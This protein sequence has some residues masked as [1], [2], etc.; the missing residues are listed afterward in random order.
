MTPD[1]FNLQRFIDAQHPAV[2]GRSIDDIFGYPDNRKFQSSMT[3]FA[4]ISPGDKMFTAALTKY[5]HG[6]RDRKTLEQL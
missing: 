3:L 2:N 6:E 4:H 5:F 1:P